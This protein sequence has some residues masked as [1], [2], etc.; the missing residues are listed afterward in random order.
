MKKKIEKR[1]RNPSKSTRGYT[2][3]WWFGCAVCEDEIIRELDLMQNAGIGGVEIQILY[4]VVADSPEKGVINHQYMSPG[5]F[6]SIKFAA[7]QA[8]IRGMAF[9]FTLGSSWP[10]GGPF[11]KIEHSAPNV[12][13]YTLDVKGPCD[14]SYDFTTR[15]YGECV[16]CV[17]GEMRDCMML[18]ETMVDISDKVKD[19]FLFGWEW[20]KE[21]RSVTVPEGDHKIIL[22]ISNEKRQTVL[23]PLGGGDGLILDH[24]SKEALDAFLIDAGNPIADFVG[25]GLVQSYFC[26]SI[27]VFGQNWTNNI[28]SEFET[29]RGYSLKPYIY[30]LWGEIKGLTELIRY[31]FNKTLSE[32]TVE[33]FFEGLTRWCHSKGTTSRIQAHGTWG[34]ILQAYAAADI[35]EGETFSEYDKYEVNTVHRKLASSAGHIYGKKIISNE[36]FTWLRFPRFVV[37]LENIKA[38]VDSIFLDGMNQIVNH[39]Y[40]Y[41]PEGTGQLGWPFYASTQINH[42]NTWWPHYKYIGEYINRVCEFLREGETVV[43]VAIYL[44][45]SDIYSENPLSDIHMAMKIEERLTTE[46]VDYIHKSGY[47]FDYINDDAVENMLLS[48]YEAIILLECVSIPVETAVGLNSYAENGGKIICKGDLPKRGCGLIDYAEKTEKIKQIFSLMHEKGKII[49]VL[50]NKE[51]VVDALSKHVS[52]DLRIDKNPNHIGFVHQKNDKSDVYFVSNISRESRKET[53]TFF[54][55][56]QRVAIYDPMTC[57]EKEVLSYRINQGNTE[58]ELVFNEYQALIFVFSDEITTNPP[59]QEKINRVDLDISHEWDFAIDSKGFS[60]HYTKLSSWEQEDDLR[61][62]S[63]EGRY[64]RLFNLNNLDKKQSVFLSLENIGETANIIVNEEEVG[65]IFMHPYE[66]DI[67][68]FVKNGSNSIEIR[69]QNLLI[70]CAIDPNYVYDAEPQTITESWP[71]HTGKIQIGR[72]ER[73]DNHRE[74]QKIKE[75][76]ASGLWGKITI[77]ITE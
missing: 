28:Y 6:M 46:V 42:Q 65:V 56:V 25:D 16:G 34:D 31:D 69:V 73:L 66:L 63:G 57:E 24:N 36:S 48:D 51:S 14:F 53:L 75:P 4:P 40:A 23:K 70:N 52:L 32:I 67:T 68:K 11:V 1:L 22:L 39:G 58:V 30:A 61:Y 41:S 10:F 17:I 49:K 3:W 7:E 45:Q 37:T 38:A 29:R 47:W 20:G 35:P 8:K 59:I 74:C 5:F 12:I 72:Q 33:Y 55:N 71:Y 9:D 54:G 15:L 64:S 77:S 26:D 18:P 60:K 21:L 2:R 43:K 62:Y 13:P 76:L 27:E 50:N 19:K 44:P